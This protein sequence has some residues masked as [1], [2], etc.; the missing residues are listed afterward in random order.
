MLLCE[1]FGYVHAAE[2][3]WGLN[4]REKVVYPR[5]ATGAHFVYC[6]VHGCVLRLLLT[7]SGESPIT[8]TYQVRS[9]HLTCHRFTTLTTQAH[10]TALMTNPLVTNADVILHLANFVDDEH[11]LFFA[12]V[13]TTWNMA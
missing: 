4:A 8:A 12:P 2:L 9:M 6:N 13:S 7:R 1:R 5:Y 11:Y 3:S 10:C